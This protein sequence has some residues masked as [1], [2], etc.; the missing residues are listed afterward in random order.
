[1]DN[2]TRTSLKREI[3]GILS[4]TEDE[5]LKRKAR[6]TT[7]RAAVGVFCVGVFLA[8][9]VAAPWLG[10]QHDEFFN[11]GG[12]DAAGGGEHLNEGGNQVGL[13]VGGKGKVTSCQNPL[14]L[15]DDLN[16]DGQKLLAGWLR[17]GTE[18]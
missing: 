18:P 15:P 14:D 7:I 10:R 3:R 1:M 13:L 8:G 5:A 9:Q 12:I 16:K 17:R 6:E 4:A 11:R 2:V